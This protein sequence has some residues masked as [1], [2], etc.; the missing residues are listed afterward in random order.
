MA[1]IT[2]TRLPPSCA[3]PAFCAAFVFVVR[4]LVATYFA[5]RLCFVFFK[6]MLSLENN[7][8][9]AAVNADGFQPPV[10]LGR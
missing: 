9:N 1:I 10:T 6:H 5:G 4:Q 8:S 7:R 3:P 2:S